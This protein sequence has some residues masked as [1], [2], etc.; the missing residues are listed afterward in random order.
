MLPVLL[1]ALLGVGNF[2]MHKAVLESRHAILEQMPA[3]L[4][5]LGGK[6]SLIAEFVLLLGALLLVANGYP[7]W[8]L[9]YLLYTLL[10]GLSAWLILSRKV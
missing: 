7:A 3:L 4:R 1:T 2:A 8:G 9:G 5:S 6:A 10:N